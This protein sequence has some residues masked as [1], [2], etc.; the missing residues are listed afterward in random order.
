MIII[1]QPFSFVYS[2]RAVQNL[3]LA[4]TL[5]CIDSVSIPQCWR[6]FFLLAIR[7]RVS[8]AKNTIIITGVRKALLLSIFLKAV[9]FKVIYQ[10]TGYD[11]D[12]PRTLSKTIFSISFPFVDSFVAQA[13]GFENVSANVRYINNLFSSNRVETSKPRLPKAVHVGA[14]CRRKRQIEV[15]RYAENKKIPTTFVGPGKGFYE[16]DPD[17]FNE[18]LAVVERSEFCDYLGRLDQ[19]EVFSL[20]GS[21]TWFFVASD[22]EG[23]SNFYIEALSFGLE[24]I[25]LPGA[26]TRYLDAMREKFGPLSEMRFDSLFYDVP[27]AS[28][29][30]MVKN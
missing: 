20:L 17:Y 30:K 23:S 29:K 5:E 1:L 26:D 19:E 9:G 14:V 18:F 7:A 3:Q 25:V 15:A 24:P 4:K 12:D 11:Y 13:P 28:W 6:E 10:M 21:S 8:N 27:V 2:G 16:E 22:N